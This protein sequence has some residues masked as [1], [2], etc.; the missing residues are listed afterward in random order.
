MLRSRLLALTTAAAAAVALVPG[1]AVQA[2]AGGLH[3]A[4]TRAETVLPPGNSMT[5]TADGQA[6]GAASGDP[7]AY[8]ANVDDQRELYWSYGFK[9]GRF[10]PECD[11][12]IVPRPGVRICADEGELVEGVSGYGVPAVYGETDADVWYGAGYAIARIRLFLI[13]AIRRTA[14]GT[15]AEL[16]GPGGVPEDVATRVTGYTEAELQ[17]FEAGLSTLA[18]TALEAYVEGVNDRIAE[19]TTTAR[20]ELPAEYALLGVEPE[21]ITTTDVLAAGVLMTRFVASDG[22]GEMANVAALQALEAELGERAGRD[23][24]LDLVWTE[25]EEASVTVLREEG[26]FPRVAGQSAAE[27]RAAFEAMADWAVGL[28]QTIAEGSGT[29]AH[30]EPM[31]PTMVTVPTSADP[32]A[33]ARAALEEWR[34]SLSGGSWGAAIA[35]SRT[36]DGST[37]LVSQPQ[38]GFDPTLLVELEVHGGGYDA[39]GT[40]VPGL[41]VV[42][43]GYGERTAWAL[44]TGNSKTVDSFVEEVRETDGVLEYR[45]DGEWKPAECRTEQVRYRAAPG[46]VPVPGDAFVEEV[47]ACRTVHGPIVA[48]DLEAGLARSI[49]YA[50][51]MREVDT[52]EGVLAWNRVD[53]LEGFTAAMRRVTWNENTIYADADGN[54]AYWHPGLHHVRD[55]RTDLRLPIPGGGEHDH[56]G[57]LAFED[58]PQVVNPA[59]GWVANWNNKPAHGWLD[60]QGIGASSLPAG[61]GHRL[62]NVADQLEARDDWTFD[63][64]RELDRRA[65]EL[66][67]RRREFGPLLEAID[68]DGLTDLQAAALELLVDGW[69]GS[70]NG[71]G[72]QMEHTYGDEVATVGPAPTVFSALMTALVDE[73][74]GGVSPGFDDL[75]ARQSAVGRHVYEMSTPLNLVLRVLDPAASS[76]EPSRDYTAGRDTDA[77]LLAAL[78]AALVDLGVEAPADLAALRGEYAVEAVCSPTGVIGPCGTMPFL[79]RGTW[80]HQV[81]FGVAAAGDGGDRDGSATPGGRALP[82]TGGGRAALG[83]GLVLVAGLALARVRRREG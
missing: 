10:R 72:A 76:L 17:G 65:A 2:Q 66:D 83:L 30:P 71:P 73:V 1:G 70:A 35:P 15:L 37:L 31:V 60:G 62:T 64:L 77:V 68:R 50:M 3:A 42:G 58:L 61:R 80:I 39:R 52:V 19:V 51:W 54:I 4:D 40:T 24:F 23:A 57:F 41:P 7:A 11:D 32:A 9:E 21:P 74:L 81:G 5:Y 49:Q 67:I 55:E 44:T 47:E 63:R 18:R 43:I 38:L 13:D 59:R 8:G 25:D 79:E 26:V 45:H 53:D 48:I 27:R 78:D 22:G 29:G 56:G 28:P 16:T 34:R 36:A 14:R 20:A 82:A 12:P 75:V 69:D 33:T 46:G 6:A